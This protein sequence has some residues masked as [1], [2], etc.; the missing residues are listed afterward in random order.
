MGHVKLAGQLQPYQ[1]ITS[2][3]LS[4]TDLPASAPLDGGLAI[5]IP[6]EL[7]GLETA[8]K[9]YGKLPW[10]RLVQPAANLARTGFG[11]HPYL[12]YVLSGPSNFARIKVRGRLGV[13][14]HHVRLC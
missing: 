14:Q 4:I 10:D 1:Y 2:H 3:A 12:V 13:K 7:R 11:A 5:A 8:W 6:N 9:R